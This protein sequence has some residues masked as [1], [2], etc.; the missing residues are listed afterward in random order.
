MS[1]FS[2]FTSK[3]KAVDDV[4]DKD[5]GLL[6]QFGGWVGNANLTAEDAAELNISTAKGVR[7]FVIETLE[8]STD[9][10]KARREIATFFIKFYAILVFMSGMTHPIDPEWSMVWFNLATSLSVGGLVAAISVFFFGSHGMVR[11]NKSK[12][13]D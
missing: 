9:R 3:A 7:E 5:N 12:S 10:S 2:I 13:D 4:F 6:T 1:I 8:E 11:V